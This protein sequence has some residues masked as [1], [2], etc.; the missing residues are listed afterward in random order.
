MMKLIV[1]TLL[2]SLPCYGQGTVKGKETM[3]GAGNVLTYS[4]SSILVAPSPVGAPVGGTVQF[5]ATSADQFGNTAPACVS[6]GWSSSNTSIATIV[7]STGL[8]TAVGIGTAT[9]SCADQ[10]TSGNGSFIVEG[11]PAFTNP[12]TPCNQPCPLN[13]GT[14]GVAY[15]NPL[16][17]A[18]GGTAPYTFSATG[19]PAWLSL[20]STG[21]GSNVGCKLGGVPN[22]ATTTNFTLTVTDS[23][24]LSNSLQVSITINTATSGLAQ[25]PQSWAVKI[26]DPASFDVTRALGPLGGNFYQCST[27]DACFASMQQAYCDWWAAPDQNWHILIQH[28][29][30]I[31]TGLPHTCSQTGGTVYNSLTI[32]S[33][34]VAG[35]LPT[36]FIVFDSD[37]PLTEGITVCAHNTDDTAVRQPPSGDISTWWQGTNWGCANDIGSMWTFEANWPG[38]GNHGTLVQGNQ[39]DLATNLG[40]SHVAFKNA[41]FRVKPGVFDGGLWINTS[42][43]LFASITQTSQMPSDFHFENIYAHGDATDWC[44]DVGGIIQYGINSVGSGYVKGDTGTVNTGSGTA[45]YNISTVTSG[46]VKIVQI[47]N[48]G[49]GYSVG[50]N[51]ATT[52]TTGVG[53]GLTLNI[54]AVDTAHPSCVTSTHTGGQGGNNTSNVFRFQDCINCSLKYSYSD[55]LVRPGAEGHN[56]GVNRG[57]GPVAVV[58]NWMSGQSINFLT[59]G[60]AVQDPFYT[61]GS[62]EVR[63]NRFTEPPSWVGTV[64]QGPAGGAGISFKNRLEFKACTNC[65]IDGNIME[66][67]DTSGAQSGQ[68][69][70]MNPRGCSAGLQ[71][72]NP[73]V[74]LQDVTIT[75]NICRHALSGMNIIGSSS[76]P[77]NGGGITAPLRRVTLSNN[78]FYDIGNSNVYDHFNVVGQ[79]YGIR[80]QNYAPSFICSGTRSGSTISLN[81]PQGP[82]GLLQPQVLPGDYIVVAGCSD[83]TW[84]LP[85]GNFPFASPPPTLAGTAGNNILYSNNSAV[86]SSAANCVVTPLGFP[87][88]ANI[89]HNT[90]VADATQDARNTAVTLVGTLPPVFTDVGCTG[91]GP[92]NVTAISAISRTGNVVTA[93]VASLTGWGTTLTNASSQ[94]I[95]EVAGATPSDLNGTFYYLGQSSGKLTWFQVG[96]DEAG[97]AG[98]T[99]AQMFNCPANMFARRVVWKNNLS[100]MNMTNAPSCPTTAAVGGLGI[101]AQGDA[102]AEGC[103]S[104][105]NANGCSQNMLDALSSTITYTDFNGRCNVKYTEMG[106]INT[107]ARPPVTLTFPTT[108][109]CP[110]ITALATCVG[111][112]NM[113]NGV[114]FNGNDATFT[115]YVLDA[116]SVYHNTADDGTDYGANPAAIET[117]NQSILYTCATA[118]GT[119]PNPDK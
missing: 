95:V 72:D 22:I 106:G 9:I 24:L 113:M 15:G 55:Y 111:L 27:P 86:A 43:D 20:S 93:T 84:N 16:L 90:F 77:A 21:C 104:G 49:S 87:S 36:K 46:I 41:E 66:Y 60:I 57:P 40:P 107:G 114:A 116:T 102:N 58:H 47:T 2:L 78:L 44:N 30:V 5:S 115:N 69:L 14:V 54:Y 35:A 3:A 56:F 1:I 23:L 98:G 6:S 7:A 28:G 103:P 85:G 94:T 39:W 31:Q 59:G 65:L 110:G 91:A 70:E 34:V 100:A 73:Q 48:S 108:A 51:V 112:H 105:F 13:F 97:S 53:S 32:L 71:C 19:A 25:L 79:P 96:A 11:S 99:A 50:S 18:S 26:I 4:P 52:R 33:K 12:V 37:T 62:L 80:V 17:T 109:V 118:C 101:N 117:A 29:T 76:Y 45:T 63:G 81:C 88:D 8:A 10:S 89:S 42:Y 83:S 82:A 119:G 92:K 61:V 38:S 64:Y 68:C 74:K 67:S 75:N